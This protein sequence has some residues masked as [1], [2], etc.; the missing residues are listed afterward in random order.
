M[1]YVLFQLGSDRYALAASCV[2]EVLPLVALKRFPQAPRGVV[3]IFI[4]RGRPVPALDLC[5]LTLGRPAQD[6]LSTRILIIN[7]SQTPGTEQLLGLITERATETLRREPKDFMDA[8][9]QLASTPFLGPVLM[10]GQGVIQLIHAHKLVADNMR[11]LLAAPL[12]VTRLPGAQPA[13]PGPRTIVEVNDA[14]H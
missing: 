13:T 12:A 4:Y 14:P 8:G 7:Q 11:E 6:R 3:G 9:V 1:L 10:D 2:V 5:E